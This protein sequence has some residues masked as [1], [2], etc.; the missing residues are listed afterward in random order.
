M[1]GALLS[2]LSK[3]YKKQL[4]PVLDAYM[5]VSGILRTAPF[6]PASLIDSHEVKVSDG[7]KGSTV[8]AADG[9]IIPSNSSGTIETFSLKS[10]QNVQEET[11]GTV[12]RYPGSKELCFKNA[13]MEYIEG[14]AQDV[15]TQVIY[16]TNSTFGNAN[17]FE[18][19]RES[20][21][22]N[23]NVI[24]KGGDVS[25]GAGDSTSIIA[26][27]WKP[28]VAG[29]L[30]NPQVMSGGNI[31]SREWINNGNLIPITTNTSTNAQKNVY[32]M[33]YESFIGFY[34]ASTKA[35]AAITQID[36]SNKATASDMDNL[37]D[38]VRAD[39]NTIV[40]ANR[41][42]MRYLK[43]LKNSKLEMMP[44]DN[45]Y[46]T[47]LTLWEGVRVQLEENIVDNEDDSLEA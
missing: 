37:L 28:R 2:N 14:I 11:K 30:L 47:R 39:S 15:A 33:L 31:V 29:M 1:A 34:A 22:D 32:Q 44:A 21:E 17:G 16:G 4:A 43:E 42:G 19:L 25:T 27:K 13:A 23:G 7:V 12:D 41:R 45:N 35:V 10:F 38:L 40:Y 36:G 26:V 24:E 46:D 6:E 3:K 9:T 18:G 8:V 20:A 5:K